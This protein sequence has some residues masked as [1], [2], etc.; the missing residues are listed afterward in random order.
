MRS[1]HYR[2]GMAGWDR[3]AAV[4]THRRSWMIALLIAVGAG[5]FMSLAGPNTG[6]DKAPLQLPPSAESSRAAALLATFPGEG[7][8]PAIL[9]VSRR[10]GARLTPADMAAAEA[11]RQR[12]LSSAAVPAGPPLIASQDGGAAVAPIPLAADL[13]GFALRDTITALRRAA[14]AGTPADLAVQL[15][16]GPAFIADITDAMSNANITLLAVT[17]TV[18]AVLLIVTYRSPV[19]WLVPLAVTHHRPAV[20]R[21]HCGNHER[22]CL[23]RRHELRAAAD[24]SLPGGTHANR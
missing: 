15:T 6:A 2:S 22:A 16:G 19:L 14:T 20:R 1:V 12:V 13:A 4:V 17:A 9:V 11:A 7:Q 8:Q 21:R 5:V 23:R 24:L 3:V 18:V 10:D